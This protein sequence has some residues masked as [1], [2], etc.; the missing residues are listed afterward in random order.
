MHRDD[1]PP[2]GQRAPPDAP[3]RLASIVTAALAKDPA[4]RPADGAA[5]LRELRGENRRQRACWRPARSRSR[6]RADV[7]GPRGLAEVTAAWE[8]AAR[9]LRS[10]RSRAARRG[11]CARPPRARRRRLVAGRLLDAVARPAERAERLHRGL[12]DASD[13]H[14]GRRRPLRRH[15]AD[16]DRADDHRCRPRRRR[17][18]P[19]RRRPRPPRRR[20][21]RPRRRPPRPRRPRPRRPPP[22]R[23]PP[24]PGDHDDCCREGALL[25]HVRPRPSAQRQR[26]RGAARRGRRRHRASRARSAA[27]ACAARSASSPP[28]RGCSLPRRRD[29]DAVIVGYPGHFDVPRARRVAGGKPLVFD[30]MISLEDELIAVRR[31]F[32]AALRPRR[33]SCA[34]STCAP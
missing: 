25:R 15:A 10:A 23:P 32:R 21:P 11:R 27:P 9:P 4:G 24:T 13:D 20:R 19:R 6:R 31:R 33:P 7:R 22:R 28:S 34:R 30:A 26:D 17:P 29:F 3:A 16:D 12:D 8:G 1:P 5:L 14:R 2:G 18:R